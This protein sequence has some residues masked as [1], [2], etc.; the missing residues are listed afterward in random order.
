MTCHRSSQHYWK[1]CLLRQLFSHYCSKISSLHNSASCQ[2]VLVTLAPLLVCRR[3]TQAL[4]KFKGAQASDTE[5]MG[6]AS[7]QASFMSQVREGERPI[8]C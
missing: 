5:D 4:E 7:R 2:C 3:V 8:M 1:T 6:V